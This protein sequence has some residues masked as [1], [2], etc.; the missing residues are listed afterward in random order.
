MVFFNLCLCLFTYYSWLIKDDKLVFRGTRWKPTRLEIRR[1]VERKQ[2]YWYNI[3]SA[4]VKI[5]FKNISIFF[6]YLWGFILITDVAMARMVRPGVVT[7]PLSFLQRPKYF[8]PGSKIETILTVQV[9]NLRWHLPLCVDPH[10]LNG[11]NFQTF[12]CPT[13]SF[14]IAPF[15]NVFLLFVPIV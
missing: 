4:Y 14:A 9:I 13:F 15:P 8:P 1:S 2:C 7:K 3:I 6:R 5:S 11:T 10:P 12:F